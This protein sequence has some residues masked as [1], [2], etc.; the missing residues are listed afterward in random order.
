MTPTPTPTPVRLRAERRRT[1]GRCRTAP[2]R[3][4]RPIARP[5]PLHR[6]GTPP[7]IGGRPGAG[8]R[9]ARPVGACQVSRPQVSTISRTHHMSQL[10]VRSGEQ[11]TD[12]HCAFSTLQEFPPLIVPIRTVVLWQ[13]ALK[14]EQLPE[15]AR[16]HASVAPATL[17]DPRFAPAGMPDGTS[18]VALL[19]TSIRST[20]VMP[21]LTASSNVPSGP[22][23]MSPG[24]PGT[25]TFRPAD[26][27]A[28]PSFVEYWT[29]APLPPM[30]GSNV[31]GR[32]RP[33]G[34]AI[35]RCAVI[36]NPDSLTGTEIVCCD[37][38]APSVVRYRASP[39]GPPATHPSWALTKCTG[40]PT[41]MES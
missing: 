40:S 15:E 5:R 12:D 18:W 20:L 34:V 26:Q 35:G 11:L 27:V 2:S 8:V 36:C 41:G 30:A 21:L 29:I 3:S 17:I 1:L 7:P 38:V 9:P 14:L 39:R 31:T 22:M 10:D 6:A 32:A 4:R 23:P 19:D 37:H 16:A 33:C 28:P 25:A 24:A 13:A